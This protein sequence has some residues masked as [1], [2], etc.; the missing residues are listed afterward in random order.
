MRALEKLNRCLIHQDSEVTLVQIAVWV[1]GLFKPS[2]RSPALTL[3]TAVLY[4]QYCAIGLRGTET[5][6]KE[7]LL[8]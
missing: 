1:C 2:F 5:V 4:L 3:R 8:C 6:L 7:H